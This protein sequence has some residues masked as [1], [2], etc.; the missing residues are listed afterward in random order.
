MKKFLSLVLALVMTMSLVTVSAGAKDFTDNSKITYEE[1]VDVISAVGVVDGYTDGSFNPTNQLTRGAAAK[2]ICNLVLGPTT[3]AAL[4]ADAAPF[5]DVPANHEFAGYIAYCSQQRII[6]GYNDGTF[7]PAAP[8]TGYAFL[9]MLLGALGY[10]GEVEGFTGPNWSIQVG[11]LALGIGL[12]DG[13]DEFVGTEYVNREEA[14]L[15]SFNTLKADMVQYDAKTSVSVGGAEVVIS[16]SKAMPVSKANGW[17]GTN[18]GNIKSDNVQQFG[19]K[20]FEKLS[21]TSNNHDEFGRPANEWK[22]KSEIVGTYADN[23]DLLA[24]YTAKAPKGELYSL[25]GSSIIDELASDS[26]DSSKT[27]YTLQFWVDGQK[28]T[29]ANRSSGNAATLKTQKANFFEKNSSAAAGWTNAIG[30]GDI[31]GQSGNGV[32]TQVFMDDDNNVIITMINTYVM[33]A[34]ADYN[35][36]RESVTVEPVDINT[37]DSPNNI[38]LPNLPTRLDQDDFNVEGVKENDYL[39]VNYS[40]DSSDVINVKV[41]EKISGTVSQYT[42]GDNVV[43]D[44]TTYKYN[45]IVGATEKEQEYSVNQDATV[46]MD[47]YGY[48]IYI[49]EAISSNSYVYIS[50]FGSTSGLNSTAVANA[51]FADGTNAEITV[52]KVGNVDKKSTIAGYGTNDTYC[53]WYTYTKDSNNNYTLSPVSGGR[54]TDAVRNA[55]GAGSGTT[56]TQIVYNKTVRFLDNSTDANIGA[57][58]VKADSKTVFVA[59]DYNENL[60]VSTGVE[61]APDVY[62]PDN[63][64]AGLAKISWVEKNG[65]ATYVFIDVSNVPGSSVDDASVADYLFVLKQNASN[66]KTV[67]DGSEYWL[68]DVIVDGEQ[69]TRYIDSGVTISTGKLYYNIKTNSDEYIT[70]GTEVDP[71]I[72]GKTTQA[73]ITLD[74]DMITKSNNTLDVAGHPYVVTSN[75]ELYLILGKGCSLLHDSGADYETYLKTTVNTLAGVV[76]DYDLTGTAYA[77]VDEAGSEELEVLYVYVSDAVPHDADRA[78]MPAFAA[79]TGGTSYAAGET[80]TQITVKLSNYA[81]MKNRGT[82][83]YTVKDP[84]GATV[85]TADS[86]YSDSTGIQFYPAASQTTGQTVVPGTYTV[87]V[88]NT[89]SASNK[90][91]ATC[92]VEVTM[93]V[94]KVTGIS[95]TTMPSKFAGYQVG[96][97]FDATGMVVTATLSDSTTRALNPSEYTVDVDLSTYAATKTVTIKYSDSITTTIEVG[98]TARTAQVFVDNKAELSY[99]GAASTAATLCENLVVSV[100]NGG[101]LD[102]ST[103]TAKDDSDG[104]ASSKFTITYSD[105]KL[106]IATKD[107]ITADTYKITVTG[108][109]EDGKPAASAVIT[110]VVA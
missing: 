69:T 39:L 110:V 70:K 102:G 104:D 16:G 94:A 78:G 27:T 74:N 67:V 88:T 6:N 109:N 45:K 92:Q 55:A 86:A 48:I 68:Y 38:V 30:K 73:K 19:E 80:A 52:K 82:L 4:S 75:T 11:K 79:P 8:L 89:V 23:S 72:S 22:Y 108:K 107:T 37:D 54:T 50:E 9:K 71:A 25:I 57:E 17:V 98:M 26:K 91:T 103:A 100:N 34:T 20:Y 59:Y 105:G 63:T 97:S 95:V 15:Y 2:I 90:A 61:N 28:V 56:N 5:K 60:T 21:R 49:D 40:Y 87:E 42:V 43:I 85:G 101:S 44:G 77:V 35:S 99:E 81:T 58:T 31:I 64:A 13:N 76:N 1:A 3:A 24:T 84:S 53:K 47:E 10:D 18:D 41:A 93:G 66:K 12:T 14:C 32:L 51:Y 83:T 29:I 106:T 96:D 65:Y 7:R 33:K 46:V 62:I 36:S